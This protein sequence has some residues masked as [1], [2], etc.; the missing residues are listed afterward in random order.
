[1]K[2]IRKINRCVRSMAPPSQVACQDTC[3]GNSNRIAWR[4]RHFVCW[5]AILWGKI[6][7]YPQGRMDTFECHDRQVR[8]GRVQHIYGNNTQFLVWS[9]FFKRF[10]IVG[11]GMLTRLVKWSD[12]YP[13]S[14]VIARLLYLSSHTPGAS[15]YFHIQYHV[16]D[17]HED[18]F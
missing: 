8:T 15:T 18:S 7:R 12:H 17:L 6:N 5:K 13:S 16:S 11:W 9:V 14:L 2:W 10:S 1:M 4:L 3:Y